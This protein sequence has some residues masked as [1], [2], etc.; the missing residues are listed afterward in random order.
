MIYFIGFFVVDSI[1]VGFEMLCLL[2]VVSSMFVF[3]FF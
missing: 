1:R 3:C 2:T